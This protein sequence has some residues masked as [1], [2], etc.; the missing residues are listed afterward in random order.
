MARLKNID[1]PRI[2]LTRKTYCSDRQI[3][4]AILFRQV[5]YANVRLALDR[6]NFCVYG[7][8]CVESRGIL[9]YVI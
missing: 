2:Y 5:E 7:G 3:D 1:L 6:K 4:I 8:V 9:T